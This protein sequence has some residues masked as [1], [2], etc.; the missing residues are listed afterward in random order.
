M[1]KY[2]D[3]LSVL[4]ENAAQR[5]WKLS[6]G[7]NRYFTNYEFIRSATEDHQ[8]VYVQLLNAVIAEIDSNRVFGTAHARIGDR[9]GKLAVQLGYDQDKNPQG[10]QDYNIWG[11]T[12]TPIVYRR[13]NRV[14]EPE[15][16]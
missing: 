8:R 3:Q 7:S 13:T 1:G 14:N 15:Q 10:I 6:S 16:Q 12:V 5:M 4:F 2:D 11:K 9:L